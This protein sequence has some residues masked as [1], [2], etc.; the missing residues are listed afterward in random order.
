MM[1]VI[2]TVASSMAISA[3]QGNASA[4]S[5]QTTN[6]ADECAKMLDK[7]LNEVEASRTAIAALKSE[8]EALKKLQ[9][10]NDA[11]L[12][13]KDTIIAAQDKR[14]DRLAATKCSTSSF[15]IFIYRTKK[16]Y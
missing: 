12:T 3:Q 14:Y 1:L 15:L 9:V 5:T 2:L 4:N 13:A 8:N 11:L 7:A 16:C 10:A 6:S